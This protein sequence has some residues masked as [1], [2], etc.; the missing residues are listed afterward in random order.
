SGGR[1]VLGIGAGWN[2]R[3][4][5][6]FGYPLGDKSTRFARFEE[7]LEVI[8]RLLRSD[9]PVTHKGGFFH[10]NEAQLLPRPA[11]PGGPRILIGGSGPRRTLPLAARYADVWNGD[12]LS[13]AGFRERS[14]ALD[15]LLRAAGRQPSD[16]KRTNTLFVVCGRS[17]AENARRVAGFRKF[18]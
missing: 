8:T 16:V 10:L 12:G 18:V 7:G 2:E 14:L 5:Q 13:P 15:E 17:A 6:V 11:R 4:H 3:E 1:M 9:G